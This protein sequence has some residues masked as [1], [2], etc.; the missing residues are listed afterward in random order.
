[1]VAAALRLVDL[2]GLPLTTD[3]A[4]RALDAALASRGEAPDGWSGDLAAV[5]ISYLF[6]I[7]GEHELLARVIPALAGIALVGALWFVR[8]HIGRVGALAA[9][10]F[11]ALSPLFVLS[12]R[13]MTEFSLGSLLAAVSV[14]CL[15]AY[16]RDPREPV[17]YALIVA[18]ALVPLTD[19]A[20][21]LAALAVVLFL[22][23]EGLLF[24][25]SDVRRGWRAFRSSP[26]QWVTAVLVVVA[27]LQLGFT[28]FGTSLRADL[29]GLGLLAE[30]FEPPRDSR[31]PEYRLALLLAYEWPLLVA[32][33]ASFVILALR[34]VRGG[35]AALT[36][37]ERFLLIWTAIAVLSLALVTRREAAQLL[38][39]LLPLALLAGSLIERLAAELDWQAV[40]RSWPVSLAIVGLMAM[41]GF[42]VTEWSA[43]HAGAAE[44]LL[45][46]LAPIAAFGLLWWARRRSRRNSGAIAIGAGAL[47]ALAFMMH[48]SFA[49]AF[50]DGA[51]F[52]VDARLQVRAERLRETL[53]ALAVERDGTIVADADLRD[54]LGWTLRDSPVVFGGSIEE[55]AVVLTRSDTAPPGFVALDEVWRVAEGWY[56][57][58]VLAPRRMWQWL[59]HRRPYDDTDAVDVRIY[60]RTA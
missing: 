11:V 51:E 5:A 43:G 57:D 59:L 1:M 48:S 50:R 54:E 26:L 16:L 3:E 56:P 21:V 28:H 32:G 33:G 18:L 39:L 6:R 23:F 30:M 12:S 49:V 45:L 52:A 10:V 20:G 24:R 46:V 17:A 7:F 14:V 8:P 22:L 53:D 15:F 44:R 19:A 60:V 38:I 35:W 27:T 2:D 36:P 42:L 4:A 13:S 47:L 41:A 34:L 25:N 9:A 55:G 37:F 31:P 40:V 29:P 58:E